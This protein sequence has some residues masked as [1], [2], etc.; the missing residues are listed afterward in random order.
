MENYDEDRSLASN[1]WTYFILGLIIF[2]I[3]IYLVSCSTKKITA[4]K[5]NDDIVFITMSDGKQIEV[6]ADE[7]DRQ[8]LKQSVNGCWVYFPLPPDTETE[9]NSDSLH[10]YYSKN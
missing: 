3:L 2:V 6:V 7:Y 5:T 4:C 8:Y 1:P 9:E 10:F